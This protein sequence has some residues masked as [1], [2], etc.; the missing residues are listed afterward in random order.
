MKYLKENRNK[1]I[2][3]TTL[4]LLTIPTT[5]ARLNR[6]QNIP[7]N[8]ISTGV[9]NIDITLT[10]KY[11]LTLKNSGTLP[12]KVR[13]IKADTTGNCQNINY[14]ITPLNILPHTQLSPQQEYTKQYTF[15]LIEQIDTHCEIEVTIEA[16]QTGVV[17]GF[18]Q[19]ETL[20]ITIDE[21]F[22]KPRDYLEEFSGIE[23][24]PTP[25]DNILQEVNTPTQI[26]ELESN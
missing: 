8:K 17:N 1:I 3:I 22:P 16:E 6:T 2:L 12:A 14:T 4:L 7:S 11:L 21:I 18:T 10:D 19:T 9:L 20:T 15:E 25:E 13:A 24:F 5:L 23:S 26:E